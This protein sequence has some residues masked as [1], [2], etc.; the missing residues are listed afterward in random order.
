MGHVH[1]TIKLEDKVSKDAGV[2]PHIPDCYV[3][4][5]TYTLRNLLVHAFTATL[6]GVVA[7]YREFVRN[8]NWNLFQLW[9]ISDAQLTWP[10]FLVFDPELDLILTKFSRVRWKYDVNLG[11][12][13]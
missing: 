13:R 12:R 4:I 8:E 11:F 9:P 2:Y 10:R 7:E 1:N 3:Q 6:P 5:A